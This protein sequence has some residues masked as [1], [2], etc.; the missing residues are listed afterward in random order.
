MRYIISAAAVLLVLALLCIGNMALLNHTLTPMEDAM[1]RAM[2]GAQTQDAAAAL[3]GL[4]ELENLWHDADA[5]LCAISPHKSLDPIPQ[6]FAR[7]RG[8]LESGDFAAAHAELR[9]A[10]FGISQIRG[11]E[12]LR[13]ANI[14]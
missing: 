7:C 3:A 12:A 8:F 6:A 9:T 5:Y 10:A 14:L 13:L 4:E 1:A 2:D 11:V